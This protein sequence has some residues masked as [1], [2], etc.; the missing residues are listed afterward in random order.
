[1]RRTVPVSRARIAS[2]L[3]A[4]T[5][6]G[7]AGAYGKAVA[8]GD[9]FAKAGLY[10]KAAAEYEAAMK[11][12]PGEPEAQI[13]LKEVRRKMSGERLAKG[14]SL[15]QRCEIAAGLA[16]LQE[17]ARLDPDSADAQRAL[18]DGNGKALSKA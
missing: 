18:T 14:N 7:C 2:L 15:I 10:E 11:L 3:L 13:K 1:M 16:A 4:L 8:R 6:A 17:A 12:D 9:D 5:L